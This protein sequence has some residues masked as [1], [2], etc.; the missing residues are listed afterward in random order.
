[1]NDDPG[2]Q[3]GTPGGSADRPAL[4]FESSEEFRAWLERHHETAPEL[5]MG[6]RKKHVSPRGL[7]WAQ[8]VPEALCFGWIDSVSQS[9]DGDTRRQRWTPRKPRSNWSAVNIAHVQR[10]V[11]DGRMRPAGLAAYERREQSRSGV[12]SYERPQAFSD[13]QLATLR[14]DAAAL[15]FW[16]EATPTYRRQATAWVLAAKQEATR[17]RRMAQ[18]IGDCAAGRLV[19]PQRYGAEPRWV[20]RAAAAARKA[21]SG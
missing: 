5:W 4:F 1:M 20:E 8:A 7:T 11:A 13:E 16:D 14:A 3:I 19:P 15:A 10:L 12:Y 21:G 6:L 18:L 2:R 17:E 9:I